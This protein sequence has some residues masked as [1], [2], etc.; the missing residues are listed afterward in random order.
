MGCYV[1]IAAECSVID[2]IKN[3][4]KD[5][6]AAEARVATFI[7]DNPEKALESNVSE[8]AELSGVSD[9]TVVRF[10]KR[11]GFAGFYQMKLQL[12][13]DFGKGRQMGGKPDNKAGSARDL[14]QIMAQSIAA[15]SQ[16]IALETIMNCVDVINQSEI[17]YVIG[18]GHSRIL[19]NDILFR[20]SRLGIRT[21]GGNFAETDIENICHGTE[22]DAVICISHSGETKRTIQALKIA[23]LRGMTTIALTDSE[24][25]PLTQTADYALASGI[26]NKHDFDG[27]VSSYLYMLAIID[28]VLSFVSK[29]KSEDDVYINNYVAESRM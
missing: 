13:H 5:M 9:A 19:A 3:N 24:K 11:L 8:T 22:R 23:S 28:A 10:C 20:L 17:I 16:R 27:S 1:N 14:L 21:A 2:N 6:Y 12:A 4:F 18:S 7:L 15:F 25:N 29:R 26:Y